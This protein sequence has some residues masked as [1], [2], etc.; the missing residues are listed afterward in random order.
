[1]LDRLDDVEE[2][3]AVCR[4]LGLGELIERM[5]A[6]LHQIVGDTG[7][8]LSQGERSRIYLA[9]ALLQKA[10]VVVL[11][12]SLAALDPEN[13]RQSLECIMRRSPTLIVIAHP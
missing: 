10:D 6:G 9:R 7:W 2:A 11:D 13:L 8:R 3:R 4:E 1:M 5:P 12:E